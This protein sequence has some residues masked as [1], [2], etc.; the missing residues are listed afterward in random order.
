MPEKHLPEDTAP[1]EQSGAGPGPAGGSK[2]LTAPVGELLIGSLV[3]VV[4]EPDEDS[5][6]W[7]LRPLDA[8]ITV[9]ICGHVVL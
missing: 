5:G 3:D 2:L 6:E 1:Q 4:S 8:G 9:N 7:R